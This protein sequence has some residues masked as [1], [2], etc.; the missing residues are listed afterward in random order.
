MIVF[1]VGTRPELIKVMPVVAALRARQAEFAIIHTGQH[2]SYELDAIFFDELG[3]PA[4]A[5]NLEVGSVPVAEQLGMIIIRTANALLD[6]KPDWVVVQGDTNS[7]LGGALA[8][9]KLGIPIA[10]LEAG[11]R[12]DDWGM[13]EEANRVLAG[14]V[15]AMHL[16]P[17][18]VQVERLR[19]ED[20]T[21]GVY[22]VGN[23]VVDAALRNA[24]RARVHSTILDRLGV[25]DERYALVTMHR[26]ANVDSRE[27]LTAIL[28]ALTA[29]GA[30]HDL[31]LVFPAHPRTRATM[32]RLADGDRFNRDPF[33]TTEPVGYLDFLGLLAG[34]QVVL[35]D[36]GGVQE[37]ACTLGIPCVTMRANTE[38]PETVA[39]GANLLCDSMDSGD[40]A[41]AVDEMLRR[42]VN[43]TNPFGDGHAG[44]RVAELLLDVTVRRVPSGAP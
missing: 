12:S 8:A 9:H 18:E 23:T 11:L 13:P 40:L 6:L 35:T 1:V 16:C 4:P 34:A 3:L 29:V 25:R 31:K 7:V 24:E 15:A 22:V 32:T 19:R 14:R 26:P 43:W 41:A 20:I 28:D 17:T 36:S 44:E 2:Y 39:V 27:R 5:V 42:P 38:R 10:H 21:R 33:I 30:K 37:E